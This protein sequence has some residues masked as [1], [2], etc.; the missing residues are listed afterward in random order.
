MKSPSLFR[1]AGALVVS[2]MLLMS[3]ACSSIQTLS[4]QVST[5]NQWPADSAGASFRVQTVKQ[6]ASA[7]WSDLEGQTYAQLVAD[8]LT[9][10][11]LHPA[12]AG[13]KARFQA[14]LRLDSRQEKVQRSQPVYAPAWG[15]P[16]AGYGWPR[17]YWH[18]G[19]WRDPFLEDGVFGWSA[20]MYMGERRYEQTIAMVLLGL[21]ISDSQQK[22]DTPQGATVFEGS[23]E[24]AGQ[25]AATPALMPY[26]VQALFSDFPGR[27]GQVRQVTLPINPRPTPAPAGK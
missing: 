19:V 22:G 9:R 16:Y 21:R 11:G 18:G 14:H 4:T 23:A 2:A 13:E 1:G 10:Q 24:Y 25:E 15:Y 8:A 6:A 17:G 26:L 5:F 3:A 20:P 27:N 7:G 12:A